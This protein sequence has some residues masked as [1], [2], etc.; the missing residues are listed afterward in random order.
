MDILQDILFVI[1]TIYAAVAAC[2][3]KLRPVWKGSSVRVGAFGCIG[4]ALGF[5][6]MAALSIGRSDFPEHLKGSFALLVLLGFLIC[7]IG[8]YREWASSRDK[9]E[10]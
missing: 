10:K 8:F 1:I 7:I 6:S 3:P 9:K 5:G 2:V 4:F